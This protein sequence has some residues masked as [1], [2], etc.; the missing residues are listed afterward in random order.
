MKIFLGNL[1]LGIPDH[2]S[3]CW[4]FIVWFISMASNVL[5]AV[6]SRAI[7]S[8]ITWVAHERIPASPAL[9][10]HCPSILMVSVWMCVGA[11][12]QNMNST[13]GLI[14][15]SLLV[16]G[17]YSDLAISAH[18]DKEWLLTFMWR[19]S[20]SGPSNQIAVTSVAEANWDG[21]VGGVF[22]TIKAV[23]CTFNWIL[24]L[25]YLSNFF[26]MYLTPAL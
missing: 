10:C 6:F 1:Q 14:G 21:F 17:N 25:F 4:C 18:E 13:F 11:V 12:I 23:A 19:M 5:Y 3:G 24:V 22:P 7:H 9:G 16:E 15:L 20:G 26:Q 2:I 8:A